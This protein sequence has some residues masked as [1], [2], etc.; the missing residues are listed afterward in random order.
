MKQIIPLNRCLQW[1]RN[2]A[3]NSWFLLALLLSFFTVESWGNERD[4][5]FDIALGEYSNPADIL[6]CK[7]TAV[8]VITD[9][10]CSMVEADMIIDESP[11]GS[12]ENFNVI[13]EYFGNQVCCDAVNMVLDVVVEDTITGDYCTGKIYTT[14]AVAPSC[15]SVTDYSILCGGDLPSADDSTHIG[16]PQFNDNC[17]IDNIFLSLETVIGGICSNDLT[18]LREW[19][20][21][22]VNGNYASSTCNQ[23]I[24]IDREQPIFPESVNYACLQYTIDD[25]TPDFTGWPTGVEM[26]C[27]FSFTYSDVI[28]TGCPMFQGQIVRTWTILD[29][30]TSEVF[31]DI[32]LIDLTDSEGPSIDA[33]P[34][35]LSANTDQCFFTGFIEAPVILE[36]CSGLESVEMFIEGVTEVSYEYDDLGIIIGINVEGNGIEVGTHTLSIVATDE[37]GN[38]STEEIDLAVVD[39]IAPT[40]VCL[41]NPS[42][43]L[44]EVNGSAQAIISVEDI[45]LEAIDCSDDLTFSFSED[46]SL[47]E[48]A[49]DCQDL[50]NMEIVAWVTDESNLTGSCNVTLTVV[51]PDNLCDFTSANE[52]KVF[53]NTV[54]YQN[55]PNPVSGSTTIGFELPEA[56]TVQLTIVDINGLVVKQISGAFGEGYNSVF[57]ECIDRRG[58][59]FYTL[60]TNNFT[61]TKK[62]VIK[63]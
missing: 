37:C 45:V 21:L 2:F 50:G 26:P 14:D 49:F 43:A 36:E 52:L 17:G 24:T 44:T 63:D 61:A 62:M 40:M 10:D 28:L 22:D 30:C 18:I 48:L 56:S 19:S 38:T 20:A 11:M 39:N 42:I 33:V 15:E 32:Q 55:A 47:T 54:L 35:T 31:T 12:N 13:V 3:N 4:Y 16:Y 34:M 8:I 5:Y 6:S 59:L 58:V 60:K 41:E 7:D 53:N 27:M 9:G 46:M 23:F 57:I 29:M 25:M 51:D 1:N